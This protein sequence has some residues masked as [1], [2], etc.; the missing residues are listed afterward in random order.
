MDYKEEWANL[1]EEQ[2]DAI[3]NNQVTSAFCVLSH[4]KQQL[5]AGAPEGKRKE[6]DKHISAAIR[7]GGECGAELA[8]GREIPAAVQNDIALITQ[9]IEKAVI[10]HLHNIAGRA[11]LQ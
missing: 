8:L 4:I 6:I 2:R 1:P 11:N 5:I 7:F 10:Q 9:E 3:S